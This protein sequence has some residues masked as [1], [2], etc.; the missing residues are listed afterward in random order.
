MIDGELWRVMIG[1]GHAPEM[2]YLYNAERDLLIAADQILQKISPNIG[3]GRQSPT[4]IHLPT[5][6]PAWSRFASCPRPRW[7][8]HRTGSPFVAFMPGSIS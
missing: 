5:I 4:R 1:R 6:S 8:C 2:I 3:V 7:C